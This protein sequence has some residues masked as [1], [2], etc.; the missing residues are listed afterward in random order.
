MGKRFCFYC[1][2]CEIKLTL[3]DDVGRNSSNQIANY[4]CPDCEKIVY[5]NY[6]HNCNLKLKKI[7]NIPEDF[8]KQEE[9][10]VENELCPRCGSNKT[11][12]VFLGN[13]G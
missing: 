12:I 8:I 2:D 11:I 9:K 5:H 4:Y 6:C 10:R 13:W 1:R 3:F 7:V